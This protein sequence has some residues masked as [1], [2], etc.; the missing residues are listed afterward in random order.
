MSQNVVNRFEIFYHIL[1]QWL[2][3][4]QKN[5]TLVSYFEDNFIT[6]VAVY[7]MGALGERLIDELEDTP[8]RISFAIDR[9][10]EN[11]KAE[12]LTVYGLDETNYPD[13]ELLIVTPVHDYWGIV[14]LLQDR[15]NAPIVSLEDIVEYCWSKGG[16]H[17]EQE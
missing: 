6:E 15:I 2:S 7:G 12:G 14:E 9:M 11:K 10:A 5:R 13:T 16:L 4:R 1:N 8:I 17:E 3:I